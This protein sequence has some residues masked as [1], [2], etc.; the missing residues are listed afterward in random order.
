MTGDRGNMARHQRITICIFTALVVCAAAG[1]GGGPA[2]APVAGVVKLDGKPKAGLIVTFQPIGTAENPDPGRGSYGQTDEQG[3]FTLVSDD[4]K[5]GAVV[6]RHLVR[7]I[8]PWDEASGGFDPEIGT[9]DGD[10][11]A[12]T[13]IEV[14]PIPPEW[15][16]ESD[17][18][19]EV[20]ASGPNE[21]NFEIVTGRR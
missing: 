4:G 11:N 19:F 5:D 2:F 14:D 6:G 17:K 12:V 21:A 7:I 15:N 10:P 16:A 20:A 9:P 8:T 1:C 18:E 13:K 3:R